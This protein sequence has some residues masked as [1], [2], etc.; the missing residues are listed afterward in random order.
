M[1]CPSNENIERT[2]KTVISFIFEKKEEL[3]KLYLK[4]DDFLLAD[5]F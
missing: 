3:T 2:K 1:A 4:S 5:F